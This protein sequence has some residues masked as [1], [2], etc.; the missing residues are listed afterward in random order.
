V[1]L[2]W[3]SFRSRALGAITSLAL[4][5]LAGGCGF[6]PL[7][8][9]AP[10]APASRA[11]AVSV[12]SIPGEAGFALRERL[13]ERLGPVGAAPTY[14]LEVDLALRTEGGALTRD[15][16]TTRTT[17]IG[18]ATIRLL[19]AAGVQPVLTET[20][21]AR[22]GYSTPPVDGASAFAARAAAR[23]AEERLARMLADRIA[24]RLALIGEPDAGA[25]GPR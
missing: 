16:T 24:L 14:R 22:T 19:P 18:A 20:V 17:L 8:R 21:T 4:L 10:E 13:V 15:Q 3:V 5:G 2:P 12:A 6:A 11:G 9:P 25:V 1:P 23:A 7:H